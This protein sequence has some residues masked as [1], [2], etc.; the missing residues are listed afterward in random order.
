M[1]R[2]TGRVERRVRARE[3]SRR[4]GGFMVSFVQIAGGLKGKEGRQGTYRS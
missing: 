3:D 2:R 1:V 4:C